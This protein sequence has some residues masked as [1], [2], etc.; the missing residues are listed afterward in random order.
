MTLI[1]GNKFKIAE[2]IRFVSI[3]EQAIL[4]DSKRGLYLGLDEIGTA[5]WHE[6]ERGA[7]FAEI[8][9]HL[10]QQYDVTRDIL[11]HDIETFIAKLKEKDLIEVVEA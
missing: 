2:E 10:L 5:I 7:A 8:C 1:A 11:A 4:L 9:E 6:I 3:E